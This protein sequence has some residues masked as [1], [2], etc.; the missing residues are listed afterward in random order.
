MNFLKT[1]FKSK[2]EKSGIIFIVEDNNAYAKTLET[3]IKSS[4]PSLTEVKLFPVGETCI[5]EL[6]RKPD[7]IIIDYFLDA[8]YDDAA[9]GLDIIKEIRVNNPELNIIVLSSQNEIG[10]VVEAIKTYKCSY[11]RKDELAF[12]RVGEIIK[13][14]YSSM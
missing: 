7:I 11:I 1:L 3:Y 13:D 10:V 9:T 8:K 4:F 5:M 6:H 14:I 2:A 12:E